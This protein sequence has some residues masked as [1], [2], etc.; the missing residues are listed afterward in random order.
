MPIV[1]PKQYGLMQAKLH[2]GS[3]TGGG[4]SPE[5]AREMIEKT[6]ASTRSK[7]AKQ[8]ASRRR[9]SRKGRR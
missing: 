5:V 8:L 7:F 2:G 3:T 6:P 9:G 1:S 4:P